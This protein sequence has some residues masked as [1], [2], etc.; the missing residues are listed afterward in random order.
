MSI[1]RLAKNLQSHLIDIEGKAKIP[2]IKVLKNL[3]LEKNQSSKKYRWS[4]N[5]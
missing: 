4:K 2:V 1:E 5:N 3:E